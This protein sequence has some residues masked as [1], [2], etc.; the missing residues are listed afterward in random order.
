M[1][2]AG[3]FS[4]LLWCLD[5]LSRGSPVE[6]FLQVG[7]EIGSVEVLFIARESYFPESMRQAKSIGIDS[8]VRGGAQAVSDLLRR[9]RIPVGVVFIGAFLKFG[10]DVQAARAAFALAGLAGVSRVYPNLVEPV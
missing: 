1:S 6:G 10:A 5:Q 9:T 7:Q 4:D 2:N 8:L 3:T